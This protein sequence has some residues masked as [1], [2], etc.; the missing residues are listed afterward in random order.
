MKPSILDA[1]SL[2]AELWDSHQS[3]RVCCEQK[4]W[5]VALTHVYAVTETKLRC[6]SIIIASFMKKKMT[7]ATFQFFPR[8]TKLAFSNMKPLIVPSSSFAQ[9][10]NTSAMGELV[11]H[12]F[13]PD[14]V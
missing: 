1:A 13:D 7:L 5:Q 11:I 12:V 10:I 8:T 9:T 4:L 6:Y 14:N 2:S 3:H